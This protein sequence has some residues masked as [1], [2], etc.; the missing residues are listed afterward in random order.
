MLMLA[1]ALTML[2]NPRWMN[3]LSSSLIVFGAALAATLLVLLIH[4][5]VLP[6]YGIN[7]G[8]ELKSTK[9]SQKKR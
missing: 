6:A 2:I 1:L 4:R 8:S 9:K 3:T 7:I 5:R